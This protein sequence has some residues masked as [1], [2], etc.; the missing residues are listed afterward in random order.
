MSTFR[1]VLGMTLYITIHADILEVS[2]PPHATHRL[3]HPCPTL[4]GPGSSMWRGP[5][6]ASVVCAVMRRPFRVATSRT[7]RPRSTATAVRSTSP[8]RSSPR[9]PPATRRP[10]VIGCLAPTLAGEDRSSVSR[11]GRQ[12]RDQALAAILEREHHERVGGCAG[13]SGRWSHLGPRPSLTRVTPPR[14]PPRIRSPREP[15][16]SPRSST[17]PAAPGSRSGPAP[18]A[19]RRTRPGSP[20]PCPSW[21]RERTSGHSTST[22]SSTRSRAKSPL[23]RRSRAPSG[24][25]RSALPALPGP[26]EPPSPAWPVDSRTPS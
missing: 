2:R 19:K 24:P 10:W 11:R 21:S 15:T 6:S 7:T 9:S 16:P 4:R 12:T 17:A 8:R 1:G 14:P 3:R 22:C 25:A 18:C 13:R 26:R 23:T 20:G 5:A